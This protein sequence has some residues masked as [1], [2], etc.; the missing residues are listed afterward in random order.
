M[1]Y[2][3]R[4]IDPMLGAILAS[5]LLAVLLAMIWYHPRVFGTAW[6]QMSGITPEMQERGKRRMPIMGFFAFLAALLVA[7]VMTYVSAAWGFYDWKGGLQLGFWIWIGFVAPTSLGSVLWE[8]KPFRL[9]LINA[10]YWLVALLLMAQCIVF[11]YS[12]QY[13]YANSGASADTGGYA[14]TE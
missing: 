1:R 5:G 6:A 11:A 7:Y 10:L 4:M 3:D 2:D 9:Y 12:L 14:Q 8:Q 13:V